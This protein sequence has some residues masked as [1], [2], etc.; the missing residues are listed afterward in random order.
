MD[1]RIANSPL[2]GIRFHL[3]AR[4]A[5]LEQVLGQVE[6]HL[7]EES[8]RRANLLVQLRRHEEQRRSVVE[9]L[10]RQSKTAVLRC[11][12][13]GLELA[14]EIGG[15]EER[16]QSLRRRSAQ[17]SEERSL[18]REIARQLL[19]ISEGGEVEIDGRAC[20]FSQASRHIF[21]LVDEEHDAT[22]HA[23]IDG[24]VQ[25]LSEAVF[26]AEVAL[27]H[28]GRDDATALDA[29]MRCHTAASDAVSG[30]A[31]LAN[32]WRPIYGE[33]TLT[34]AV[35]ALLA[36]SPLRDRGLLFVVGAE[37]RF[38]VRAEMVAYRIIEEALDNAA[39]HAHPERVEVVLSY[40]ADRLALLVKDDGDGFDVPATEARLGRTHAMGLISMRQRAELAGGRFDLRSAVGVGTEIR[41]TLRSPAVTRSEP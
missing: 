22:A 29:A 7:V 41:A 18:L 6:R 11:L 8:A 1:V 25:R 9:S 14:G 26:E 30:M 20:R 10:S 38:A 5:D 19:E 34:S 33:R 37:R 28:T 32:R 16:I 17:L 2:V 39:R 31:R 21:R 24:P 35:G 4:T 12:H 36:E 27:Q 40:H 15:T 13:D 3:D 23:L